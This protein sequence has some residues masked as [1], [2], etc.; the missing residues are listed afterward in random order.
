MIA[1]HSR[2]LLAL[3]SKSDIIVAPVVVIPDM[4]SKKASLRVNS[5]EDNKNGK[6][7]K[8]A[9]M[10]HASVENKKVCLRFNLNSF[11]KLAKINSIPINIVTNEDEMKL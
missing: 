5:F 4:L 6:L 10:S 3:L 2:I 1:L 9:T 8:I 11:S 7:P